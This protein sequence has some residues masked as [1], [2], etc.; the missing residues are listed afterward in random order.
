M[1]WA[2]MDEPEEITEI[3]TI[4]IYPIF[5]HTYDLD[6]EGGHYK[7]FVNV[8]P[9]YHIPKNEFHK[10]EQAKLIRFALYDTL[11]N[12][13]CGDRIDTLY[14]IRRIDAEFYLL[15]FYWGLNY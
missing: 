4:D 2:F 10:K 15:E 8:K 7:R 14:K 3:G 12:I 5:D 11:D 6:G 1:V 13:E 9:Y